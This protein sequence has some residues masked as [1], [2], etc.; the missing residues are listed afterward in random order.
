MV[1]M[2]T[3]ILDCRDF[4]KIQILLFAPGRCVFLADGDRTYK[5]TVEVKSL[6]GFP[7]SPTILQV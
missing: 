1:A 2:A 6:R 5:L 7:M 3:F 4:P